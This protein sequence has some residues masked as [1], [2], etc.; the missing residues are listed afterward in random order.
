MNNGYS[1]NIEYTNHVVIDAN[2]GDSGKGRVVDNI[3]KYCLDPNPLVV[4]FSGSNNAGHTVY[5]NENLSNVFHLLGSGS[6][7]N[8][9]TYLYKHVSVDIVSLLTRLINLKNYIQNIHQLY[10]LI[11]DVILFCLLILLLIN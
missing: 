7:R 6:F 5:L 11:Q 1:M 9:P 4:R 2:Y 10:I 8:I 3:S